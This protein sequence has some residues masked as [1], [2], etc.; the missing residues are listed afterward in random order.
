[1]S[2]IYTITKTKKFQRL[3]LEHY[4]YLINQV[5]KFEASH[6]GTKRN[7]N[8]TKFIKELA[9]DVGASPS[10]IYAIIKDA[11][12]TVLNSNLVKHNE[13][14]AIAAFNKRSKKNKCSNALKLDKASDFI[15]LVIQKIKENSLSSIDETI[16]AFKLYKSEEI[17][18]MTT[19]CPKTLY[20][21]VHASL[22]DLKPIDL[23]RT[24]QR[25]KTSNYKTYI[26]KSQKGTSI[27][28]R[29]FPFDDRSE[30]GH[31]ERDLVVGPRDGQT[32]A[33]LT[34]CERKT[35]FYYAIKISHKSA[36]QVY[37][38][39]NK[40]EKLFGADFSTIFKSIT[41]DNGSEFSR[42]KDIERKPGSPKKRTTVYFGRPYRSCDR[43]SNEN[44]NG[45]VRYFYKKGTDFNF[46][47]K[48]A[49]RTMNSMINHKYRKIHQYK[50]AEMLFIHELSNLC[51]PIPNTLYI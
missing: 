23:P 28:E 5:Q 43:G 48:E 9:S 3:S 1:M 20:N 16:H 14:S 12:I 10:T 24:V 41:F 11:R 13:L 45:L 17:K 34:L 44:C 37:M 4:E 30:F 25:K 38:Q 15:N 2:N 7:T 6:L 42:Y 29:P 46:V 32:G 8:K 36:K 51:I 33:L 35:R 26:P 27:T 21:Y 47:S 39:F 18:G 50:S 22:V 19:I 49:I 40:L 31:W